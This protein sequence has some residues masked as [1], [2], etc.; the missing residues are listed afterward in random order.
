MERS[1]TKLILRHKFGAAWRNVIFGL[2]VLAGGAVMAHAESGEPTYHQGEDIFIETGVEAPDRSPSWYAPMVGK[3]YAPSFEMLAT[4]G[5]QGRYYSYTY[6]V[7]LKDMI[8]FHG[9]DCEGTI[10][11]ANNARIAFDILF[12]DGIVDRSVLW[13]ISGT[14]PCWS[15]A[16][17]F[18][19]GARLQYG[20][21][22]YFKDTSYSHAIV[23][24]REDTGVAVLATWKKGINNIPG[25]PVMLPGVIDWQTK[26][27][28]DAVMQLKADVK[29]AGGTPTPYQVDKLRYLQ[30]THVNDILEHP[31]EMSYQA[32]VI[33]DFRWE[34]WIDPDKTIA[35]P[36]S[37]GD[38]RLK[39]YPYRDR[40]ISGP[41]EGQ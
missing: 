25:E 7:T 9:H 28:T 5:T 21:L 3:P 8:K 32:Q 30:F 39:N 11:A 41:E 40:P 2:T 31:L 23:L 12:P 37:R 18:L 19:T 27:D 20:N 17:V 34:D 1:S 35:K 6:P 33:E 15:D 4:R 26:V 13:G 14:S 24:Y 38:I 16:V 29:T 10:H 36:H 22:G